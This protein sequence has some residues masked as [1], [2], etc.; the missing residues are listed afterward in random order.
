[1]R[2]GIRY[3]KAGEEVD[4]VFSLTKHDTCWPR[5]TEP[6]ILQ[7]RELVGHGHRAHVNGER[8]HMSSA[9]TRVSVIVGGFDEDTSHAFDC[10]VSG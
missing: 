8:K 5:A 10:D 4:A 7:Q 2:F 6:V 9:D 1:M 3:R